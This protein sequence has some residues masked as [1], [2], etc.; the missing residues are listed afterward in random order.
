MGKA[1]ENLGDLLTG[2]PP[3]LTQAQIDAFYDAHD[4]HT[5]AGAPARQRHDAR[6]LRRKPI[7][8]HTPERAHRSVEM[9]AGLRRHARPRNPRLRL[10]RA[11]SKI[12]IAFSYSDGFGREIQKKIQAKPGPRG[13]RR[14]DGRSALGRQRLDHLQ[15][16]RQAGP[17][18]RAL[19]QPASRER[20]PIRVWRGSGRESDPL[21]RPRRAAWSPR[22]I[23]TTPTRKS[24]SIP[25][26]RPPGTSTTPSRRTIPPPIQTWAI[27]SSVCPPADFSPTWRV[28]R[29]ERRTRPAGAGRRREGCR[30]RQHARRSHI[31]TRWAARSSR[32]PITARTAST[33]LAPELDIQGNQRSRDRR[34]GPQGRCLTTT[35]CPAAAFISPA[36]KPASAGCLTD[37]ARKADPGL[38]QPR[39]QFPH[40]IRRTAPAVNLFVLGTDA[41]NSDPRT[42]G[43]RNPASR[44]STTAKAS[45]R[46][47]AQSA[48]AGFPA[49]RYGR[50]GEE[51][52]DTIRSPKQDVA[53]DFKGNLLRSSRQFIARLMRPCRTGRS[54]RPRLNRTSS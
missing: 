20:T 17:A 3:D 13:R 24:C 7:S 4:P 45:R 50:G 31:S 47:G 37:A 15:Q 30:A 18:V 29:A 46:P 41:S 44:R 39:P 21:L 10:A 54:R 1:S 8:S 12:Q 16:Q 23:P 52:G 33:S 28:Q 35:R 49:A 27:S 38:G 26:I 5:L 19:L 14:T 32:L 53:Y 25:G 2:F 43:G 51:R 6:R 42:I 36:W 11:P 40:R 22:F 34:A 48:H 9:A